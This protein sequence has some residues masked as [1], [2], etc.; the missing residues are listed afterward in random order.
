[1]KKWIKVALVTLIIPSFA[2][3]KD[4]ECTIS[5][6]QSGDW[7]VSLAT[8]KTSLNLD[9]V[10]SNDK[11]TYFQTYPV[12]LR[13]SDTFTLGRT[14]IETNKIEWLKL[15]KS[16]KGDKIYKGVE[17]NGN[18]INVAFDDKSRTL[19]INTLYAPEKGNLIG[20]IS[21]FGKCRE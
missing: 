13:I 2:Y 4:I 3:S 18:H 16:T 5:A 1:M 19:V 11:H 6:N 12:S 20:S 7:S 14:N 15:E 8:T 21:E 17:K 9:Q 10:S